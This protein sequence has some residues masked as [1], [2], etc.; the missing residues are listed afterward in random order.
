MQVIRELGLVQVYTGKGKGKTTA[1]LGLAMRAVGHGFRVHMIQFMKGRCYAGE[2]LTAQKLSPFF[3]VSQFGRGCRIGALI[4]QGYRKCIGCGDCF[5]KDR[6]PDRDDFEHAQMGL[7][8][9]GNFMSE[10]KADIVILDE[11]GNALRY[12]LVTVEQV[13]DLIK[14]KPKEVEL[15]L[16]GRGIPQEILDL[17]DL[18]TEMNE[19]S[20]PF[21]KGVTSRRGIEY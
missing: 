21:K 16:T 8:E 2:I 3:T 19:I 17:A 9:A 1:A 12:K 18:V 7:D 13:A 4:R 5:I 6:G 14:N 11:I 20:H 15:V 10:G